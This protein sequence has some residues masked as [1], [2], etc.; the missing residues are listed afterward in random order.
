MEILQY[1]LLIAVILVIMAL[2]SF[3]LKASSGFKYKLII[4]ILIS[5]VVS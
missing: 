1:V 3:I 4:I 2:I 5:I